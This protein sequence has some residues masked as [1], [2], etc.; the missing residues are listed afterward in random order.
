[1]QPIFR[2]NLIQIKKY[3]KIY[4][5]TFRRGLNRENLSSRSSR[6]TITMPVGFCLSNRFLM[7]SL[8]SCF[9]VEMPE[10]SDI[11]TSNS[12]ELSISG[13]LDSCDIS[14]S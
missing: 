12:N 9:L 1:M 3:S 6:R 13:F 11:H 14:S 4:Y 7:V 5:C 8:K 2:E 10:C